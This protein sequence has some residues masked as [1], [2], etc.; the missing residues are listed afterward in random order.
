M[1][2]KT[3]FEADFSFEN[4]NIKKLIF[5]DNSEQSTAYLGNQPLPRQTIYP[6]TTSTI[7]NCNNGLTAVSTSS[8]QI[9]NLYSVDI[10]GLYFQDISNNNLSSVNIVF[11]NSYNGNLEITLLPEISSNPNITT[12][13]FA[14]FENISTSILTFGNITINNNGSVVA[15][16]KNVDIIQLNEYTLSFYSI[17]YI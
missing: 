13:A 6:I 1:S 10:G 16:F 7:L 15:M 5:N 8:F 9:V 4:L 12:S 14:T 17:Q 11:S 2:S 3:I